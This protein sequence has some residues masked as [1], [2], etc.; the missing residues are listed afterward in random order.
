MLKTTWLCLR[1]LASTKQELVLDARSWT[2]M[3]TAAKACGDD[4]FFQEQVQ[5]LAPR[6]PMGAKTAADL[7]KQSL[8]HKPFS[9]GKGSEGPSVDHI[10]AFQYF[11]EKVRLSF[12]RMQRVQPGK[13]RDLTNHPSDEKTIFDWPDIAEESWQRRL[14]E[15]ST[16]ERNQRS[17]SPSQDEQALDPEH[18]APA[19]SDT[20]IRLD[21]LRYSNWK[22][23]NKLL[24]QTEVSEKRREESANATMK[25]TRVSPQPESTMANERP[26]QGR[27]IVTAQQ[28][29]EY[30][31]DAETERARRTTEQ[32]WRK[33]ILRLRDP[34][35][36]LLV[37]T[38]PLLAPLEA[39]S[40]GLVDP[41][42]CSG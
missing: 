33:R 31:Q 1:N 32:E 21:G 7:A 14:Y 19:V 4:E 36:E 35:Y 13:F 5:D 34:D 42:L 11:C 2:I 30:Q 8:L 16:S 40:N 12:E 38:Q 37:H 27:S 3:A 29:Q 17:S 6:L 41:I 24:V 10:R 9:A 28:F 26:N 25:E 23:I 18:R 22:T 15:E 20:G 39:S